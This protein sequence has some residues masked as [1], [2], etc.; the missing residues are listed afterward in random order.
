MARKDPT[1][2]RRSIPGAPVVVHQKE[3]GRMGMSKAR[4]PRRP[5]KERLTESDDL[6]TRLTKLLR[7]R[8]D[9]GEGKRLIL[10]SPR[11]R[12]RSDR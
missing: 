5:L 4:M 3:E 9:H 12:T 8:S 7:A 10:L 1:P 2:A 11:P 6:Q